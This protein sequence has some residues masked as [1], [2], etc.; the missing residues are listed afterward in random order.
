MRMEGRKF[1]KASQILQKIKGNDI[2]GDWVTIAVLASSQEELQC[3][4]TLLYQLLKWKCQKHCPMGHSQ[5]FWNFSASSHIFNSPCQVIF[6]FALSQGKTYGLWKLTDLGST[7]ANDLVALF[8]FDNVYKEHWKTAEGTVIALLNSNILPAKDVSSTDNKS[9]R[10]SSTWESL[11]SYWAMTLC[12]TCPPTGW[13][14]V[15]VA[16]LVNCM[17]RKGWTSGLEAPNMTNMA[18][19]CMIEICFSNVRSPRV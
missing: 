11:Y 8:L 17:H 18:N 14:C 16:R 10:K 5:V 7:T 6:T 12:I 9:S 19:I 3:E 4:F 13:N 2:E 15:V 1:V